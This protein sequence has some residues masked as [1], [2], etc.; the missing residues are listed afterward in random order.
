MQCS[1][2][3]AGSGVKGKRQIEF[4]MSALTAIFANCASAQPI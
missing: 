1:G 4:I 2:L 3:V